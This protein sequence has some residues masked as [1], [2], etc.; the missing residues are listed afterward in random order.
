MVW[1]LRAGR[2]NLLLPDPPP[3]LRAVLQTREG[4]ELRPKHKNRACNEQINHTGGSEGHASAGGFSSDH[5]GKPNTVKM[6]R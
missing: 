5:G 1:S 3:E 2:L 4:I 6:I